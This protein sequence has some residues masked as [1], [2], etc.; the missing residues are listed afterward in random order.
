VPRNEGIVP[1]YPR[2]DI[3]YRCGVVVRDIDPATRRWTLSDPA[4]GGDEGSDF[5]IR[6]WQ[7]AG[8]GQGGE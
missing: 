6:S 5:D 1:P 3:R 8:T 7:R 2:V 4:F